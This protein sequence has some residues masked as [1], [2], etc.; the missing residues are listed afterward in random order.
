MKT[1][2]GG[3]LLSEK[4]SPFKKAMTPTQCI[5]Y[6]LTRPGVVS[7]M[8]G[9][10]SAKEVEDSVNYLNASF[11]ERDYTDIIKGYH[12]KLNDKCVYCNHCQ[13]CPSNI[14]IAMVNK[15]LDK[16]LPNPNP[17]LM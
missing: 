9:C 14:D 15:Y 11:E 10:Q 3:R 7:A 1:F 17:D 16:Q 13:P 2:G 12:G 8:V 5:H 6:A 4:H